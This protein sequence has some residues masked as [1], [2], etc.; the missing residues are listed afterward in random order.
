MNSDISDYNSAVLKMLS[1]MDVSIAIDDLYS[2]SLHLDGERDGQ[3]HF[4]NEG[5]R[6][7][8]NNVVQSIYSVM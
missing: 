5:Y 3:T 8:G 4:S 2:V 7:I 1:E 6:T